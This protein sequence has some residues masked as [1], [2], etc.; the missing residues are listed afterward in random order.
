[1]FGIVFTVVILSAAG[2]IFWQRNNIAAMKY[3]LVNSE[4]ELEMK[5]LENEKKTA[6]TMERLPSRLTIKD[7]SEEEK[8][9][10]AA[11][12]ITEIEAVQIILEKSAEPVPSEP[13]PA[14][15]A[16]YS[17][18]RTDESENAVEP[19]KPAPVQTEPPAPEKDSAQSVAAIIAEVYVLRAHYTNALEDMRLSAL[20]DYDALPK[21]QKT[22]AAKQSIGFEY[23]KRA[24]T[25]EAECDSKMD[26]V[27]DRLEKE[28]RDSG[29]DVSIIND[30]RSA[31][32]NEKSLMKAYYM[33]MYK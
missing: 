30:V 18:T 27:L 21:E 9:K 31:Y 19:V 6:E 25:L 8:A 2:I 22:N 26:N 11:N 1:M 16:S 4:E 7:L 12:E 32:A 17:E 33:N 29:N 23:L 15:P 14:P 24:G 13:E 20:A 10:L 28:L 5:M 3:Y